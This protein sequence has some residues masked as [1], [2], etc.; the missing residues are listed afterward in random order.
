MNRNR[1]LP[2][3][4]QCPNHYA[5][6]PLDFLIIQTGCNA[7]Q[8]FPEK[9]SIHV[10]WILGEKV[11]NKFKI[12]WAGRFSFSRGSITYKARKEASEVKDMSLYADFVIH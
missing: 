10:T 6:M 3:V 1:W 7:S 9:R 12:T 5:L 11:K 8:F 2:F 4:F